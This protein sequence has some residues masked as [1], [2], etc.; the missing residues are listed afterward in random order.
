M[1]TDKPPLLRRLGGLG[2]FRGRR[3]GSTRLALATGPGDGGSLYALDLEFQHL[4]AIGLQDLELEIL[5]PLHYLA[6]RRHMAGEVEYEAPDGVD[7][8]GEFTHVEVGTECGAH[9]GQ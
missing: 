3:F 1:R 5:Q 7:L 4:A 8:I 6:R 2:G 9:L